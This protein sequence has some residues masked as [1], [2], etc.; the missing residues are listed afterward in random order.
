MTQK[1]YPETAL[2]RPLL[3]V[4][5]SQDIA[6]QHRA[7]SLGSDLISDKGADASEELENDDDDDEDEDAFIPRDLQN[8]SF[9]SRMDATG[10]GRGRLTVSYFETVLASD[11]A[12]EKQVSAPKALTSTNHP[13][14]NLDVNSLLGVPRAQEDLRPYYPASDV[15]PKLWE[16]YTQHVDIMNKI[17]YKPDVLPLI[18]HA[19][20]GVPV[21]AAN[22]TLLFGIWYSVVASTSGEQCISLHGAEKKSLLRR[23]R[24]ALEQS[25]IQAGWMTTQ[26]IVVLQS[27]SLYLV[28]AA[29]NSRSTWMLCGIAIS[30]AQAMGL[31]TDSTSFSLTPVETEVR[32]RVW[33]RLCQVDVRVSENCG[34]EPH[35]PF[36]MDTKLPLNI[37]DSDLDTGCKEDVTSRDELTEM[38]L[39]LIK[40][41]MAYTNLRFKRAQCGLSPVGKEE[42]DNV[43]K[44]QLQR[45]REVYL[46]Y[47]DGPSEFLRIC[48]LGTRLV[49]AR[50]WKHMHDASQPKDVIDTNEL[51]EPLLLYNA[52]V[53]EIAN[54]LP[55]KYRQYGWFFR[56]R[57]TQWHAI[58]YILIQLCKHTRGTAVDRAWE[59]INAVFGD[60]D[61]NSTCPAS[62]LAEILIAA[63]KNHLWEAVLRLL[64]KVR[65]ERAQALQSKEEAYN[66]P[67][68]LNSISDINTNSTGLTEQLMD[69]CPAEYVT[70]QNLDGMLGDPFLGQSVDF[71][72]EMNWEQID[73]WVQDFQASLSQSDA[74][75]CQ[76]TDALGALEWW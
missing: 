62:G 12:K 19:S 9:E 53:L 10:A 50:L 11:P 71:G 74:I 13:R 43:I 49:M 33:W 5:Q 70:V 46:K 38:T 52:D 41:E 57:Y 47:F 75:D 64:K 23:Y 44:D 18:M 51:N 29:E 69:P 37:N 22:E 40:I 14:E 45:Y 25:L 21:D 73:A 2:R 6:P 65:Y 68:T 63:R 59:V 30:L 1:S 34:L 20:N 4:P 42:R 61:E 36:N 55:D 39:S 27:I 35:V 31:H 56:C 66:T 15:A 48:S 3:P 58:T 17:L 76:E 32:R 67:S 8:D 60:L 7:D 72:E 24:Y 26:R 54:Q 16:Y 28:F